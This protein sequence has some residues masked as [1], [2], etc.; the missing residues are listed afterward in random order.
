MEKKP[1]YIEGKGWTYEIEHNHKRRHRTHNYNNV[2]TY[3]V[4]I[5][6]KGRKPVFGHIDGNIKASPN[7]HDYPITILSPLG[8]K[9]LHEEIPKI[10]L[11]FP[12]VDVWKVCIMPDHIHLILH[13]AA[14]LPPNKTLG[15]IIGAF[16]GGISRAW[17]QA[18]LFEEGFNDRILM[19][20][21]QLEN[22]KAYLKANPFRW[23]VRHS[24]IEVM[25]RA[26]CLEING[27]RYGAFGN[28]MLL[29]HPEKIQVFFHRK[30]RN[31]FPHRPNTTLPSNPILPQCVRHERDTQFQFIP[32]EQTLFWQNE[33]KR[34]IERA[35]QG[36]V[37]VTPGISECEKRI[38]NECIQNH[39]RLI[40]LQSE[41][42]GN[43]WKPEKSRFEACAA[44]TLLILAP[45]KEDLH[46]LSDYERFHNL[47]ALA[48]DICRLGSKD[49]YV[50]KNTI[51]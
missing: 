9:V 25:K 46:G 27:V 12:M 43:Y 14:Q 4:T 6:T 8:E 35:I 17:G 36:D 1:H 18:S 42:I 33:C 15:T 29:R 22:W 40:H 31:D 5:I 23:L 32:T 48:E 47:N 51:G 16:K 38:K 21:G 49:V 24:R 39:F 50:L 2:G 11:T 44:G 7:D 45:W 30:M 37:I 19:R 28:F 10:H 13:V 34:L 26:L 41:A 20:N 3:M